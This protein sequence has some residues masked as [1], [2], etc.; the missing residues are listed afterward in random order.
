MQTAQKNF[1]TLTRE[2]ILAL[3]PGAWG[4]YELNGPLAKY[5][6]K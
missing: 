1:A 5:S 3:R 2:Q 4:D 6:E